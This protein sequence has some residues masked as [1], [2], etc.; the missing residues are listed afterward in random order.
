MPVVPLISDYAGQIIFLP[1]SPRGE[2]YRVDAQL[3]EEGS[4]ATTPHCNPTRLSRILLWDSQTRC[5]LASQL[6]CHRLGHYTALC[7]RWTSRTTKP[8]LKKEP[9][10]P[11]GSIVGHGGMSNQLE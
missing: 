3:H 5:G 7:V 2:R 4:A 11:A 1:A 8:H 6:R 9:F 10:C